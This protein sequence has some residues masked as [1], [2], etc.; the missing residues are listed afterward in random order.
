MKYNIILNSDN[1]TVTYINK[2][3]LL[4]DQIEYDKLLITAVQKDSN[5]QIVNSYNVSELGIY[6]TE[7]KPPRLD[8]KSNLVPII[9]GHISNPNPVPAWWKEDGWYCSCQRMLK[10]GDIVV[11]K[12]N[13]GSKSFSIGTDFAD[14]E[15]PSPLVR[16]ASPNFPY[17]YAFELDANFGMHDDKTKSPN[18][19]IHKASKSA[20]A[21]YISDANVD[22]SWFTEPVI[23]F[24]VIPLASGR[25]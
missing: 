20:I 18:K 19:I 16:V 17:K 9:I 24:K 25:I 11:L 22:Y 4:N 2:L 10:V 8:M 5:N 1:P 14:I 3:D 7:L 13:H 12:A 6:N 21:F 23:K 15:N